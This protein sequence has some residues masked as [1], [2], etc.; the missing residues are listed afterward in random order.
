[1]ISPV[2]SCF[3]V[4]ALLFHLLAQTRFL[5]LQL[6]RERLAEILGR[7]ALADLDLRLNARWIRAA[8]HP[9]DRF[10]LA[11]ALPDPEARDELLG[12]GERPIGDDPLL[13]DEMHP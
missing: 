6:R 4:L 13:A 11:L 12:L 10:L 9:V 1:M 5:L 8:L 2:E 3:L 7:E